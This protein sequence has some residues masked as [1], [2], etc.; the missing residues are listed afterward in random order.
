MRVLPTIRELAKARPAT[1]LKLW[2]GLGC[3]A[4]ARN[5]HGSEI[6]VRQHQVNFADLCR[7]PPCPELDATQRSYLQHRFQSAYPI[8]D[9]NV[10]RVL[11]RI[12]AIDDTPHEKQTK[13][14]FG[15]WQAGWLRARPV[16]STQSEL[17]RI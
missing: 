12:Y 8:L 4:R 16:T 2:E 14:F 3:Y 9:G 15:P 6:I 10:I 5:L 17:L 7:Y 11:T 1:V 13:G